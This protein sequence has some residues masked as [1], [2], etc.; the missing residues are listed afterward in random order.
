MATL[1]PKLGLQKP[2]PNV[3]LDWAFRLNE[4][5]DILDDAML[6]ANVSGVGSI[7]VTDDGSGN[8]TISGTAE[9]GEGRFIPNALVGSDGI[10]VT[11]GGPTDDI[12]GFRGEFINASGTLQTD[13]DTNTTNIETNVSD[14]ADNTTLITTTSGH[15]QSEIDAVEGSDVDDINSVVGS[16]TIAG[17]GEVTVSTAGQTITISGTDH[18][19]GGGGGTVSDALVGVDGITVLSGTPTAS[20]TTISGFRD[21]FLSASGTFVKKTGDTMTGNLNIDSNSFGI[22]LGDNQDAFLFHDGT[23]FKIDNL[24]GV[25]DITGAVFVSQDED[26]VSRFGGI[27]TQVGGNDAQDVLSVRKQR[28]STNTVKRGLFV[29]MDVDSTGEINASNFGLNVFVNTADTDVSNIKAGTTPGGGVAGRYEFRHSSSGE[30]IRAGGVSAQVRTQGDQDGTTLEGY[31]FLDEGGRGGTG[32]GGIT[33]YRGLWIRESVGNVNHKSGIYI[34]DLVNATGTNV[35][36]RIDGASTNALWLGAGSAVTTAA[37]GITFGS[38]KDVNLYRSADNELKTDDDFV[39]E[40]ITAASGTFSDSLTVSGIPVS[41]SKYTDAEAITALGPTTSAL[42]ASGVATDANLVSVSGHLQSEVDA[43][44]SSVTLQEAYDNGD[45]T[46][47]STSAKP[48]QTG[49]LTVT[50]SVGIGTSSPSTV[51]TISEAGH[52]DIYIGDVCAAGHAGIQIGSTLGGCNNYA[53]VSNGTDLFLN[54]TSGADI[55]FRHS[56]V[57]QMVIKNSGNVGIGTTSPAAKLHV[58]SSVAGGGITPNTDADDLV[59][60]NN[61][62]GGISIFTPDQNVGRLYFGVPSDNDYFSIRGH[63]NAGTPFLRFNTGA[64]ELVRIQSDGKVGIGTTTPSHTLEVVG[65][66]IFSDDL[67]VDGSVGIGGITPVVQLHVAGS[68][69]GGSGSVS[70]VTFQLNDGNTGF[71]KPASNEIGMVTNGVERIRVRATGDVGI[72]TP[73]PTGKLEVVG[74][75][76]T[77]DLTTT[78]TIFTVQ[79]SASNPAYTFADDTDTGIF[80]SAPDRLSF[81]INGTE[82]VRIDTVG[83]QRNL[84]ILSPG[85]KDSPMLQFNDT[86]TGF[87]RAATDTLSLTVGGSELTRWTQQDSDDDFI[88]LKDRIGINTAINASPTH[89]LQVAGSGIFSGDFTAASGTFTDGITAPT[90]NEDTEFTGTIF[91]VPSTLVLGEVQIAPSDDPDRGISFRH[92]EGGTR[93][94]DLVVDGIRV[95]GIDNNTGGRVRAVKYTSLGAGTAS[96][97]TYQTNDSDTGMYAPGTNQLGFSAGG[98]ETLTISGVNDSTDGVGIAGNL[99]VTGT[100]TADVGTFDTSLTISG[101][102]VSIA[103]PFSI[104]V[105]STMIESPAEKSYTLD[106]SARYA[107]TVDEL[108]HVTAT[109]TVIGTLSIDGT[110]VEGID[111]FSMDITEGTDISTS[112]NTVSIGDTLALTLSGIVSAA[113]LA[114]SLQTTR[115]S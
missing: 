23:D 38:G 113:D 67:K 9:V 3:E 79:G 22:N 54:R 107:Y 50:G 40:R 24:T 88:V 109:G 31:A 51:L 49:D 99:T 97:P 104:E 33:D 12:A 42:A 115:V 53:L 105:I 72:G 8:V 48:V 90:I 32:V 10:T 75:V 20:E 77:G 2:V 98:T 69:R 106:Q 91:T 64:A 4:T 85:D 103:A 111:N 55:H 45:G 92:T 112:A 114:F 34:E 47:A 86:N 100:V 95:L 81:A 16:I 84:I 39:A 89:T 76:L 56:N 27:G 94:I 96:V 1:T 5:I 7:T 59:V 82:T 44:D 30:W 108:I 80:S 70:N 101:V 28:T 37:D 25:T 102:P 78:G 74:D 63:Y 71:Y 14:I 62:N 29:Q 18:T 87:F 35:G 43:I 58:Q 68:I 52:P 19:A 93:T 15:L 21:E 73:T 46:I 66:G 13:I 57:T 41:T 60:E 26:V 17:A 65:S 36:I 83:G 110:E 11:S 61:D 6:T